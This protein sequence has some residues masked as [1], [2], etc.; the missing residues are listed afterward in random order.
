MPRYKQSSLFMQ[1]LGIGPPLSPPTLHIGGGGGDGDGDGGCKG[2]GG[3]GGVGEGGGGE[4]GGG[5]AGGHNG[6]MT[7]LAAVETPQT[8][9]VGFAG[10]AS[11]VS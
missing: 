9:C 5:N 11:V 8:S 3:G 2:D 1:Q 4:D 6:A 7:E 10:G